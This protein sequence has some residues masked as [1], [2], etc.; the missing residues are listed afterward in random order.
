V[1]TCEILRT[2]IRTVLSPGSNSAI[3]RRCFLNL[4]VKRPC[5]KLGF[6]LSKVC[7]MRHQ[8]R[9]AVRTSSHC[10]FPFKNASYI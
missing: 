6:K 3:I 5:I 1:K 10:K 2:S 4:R 9:I 8:L 7:I